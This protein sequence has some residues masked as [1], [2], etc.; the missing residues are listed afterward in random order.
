MNF[1]EW[2]LL[3]EAKK[4]SD[5]ARE[6]LGNNEN[7]FNQIKSIIPTDIKQDLQSKLV[8]VA[9]YYHKQQP[10]LNTLKQDINDYANLVKLNKMPII[11]IKD[12]HTIDNKHFQNYIGWTQ[13]IHGKQAEDKV[14]NAPIP[15]GNLEDQELIAKSTDGKIKVY[16]AN[17]VNQCIILGKGESFCISQPANTMFQSYRDTKVSTFYFVYDNTRSDDL[18]IV[19]VDATKQRIELTDRKNQ[20]AKTMQDPYSNIP[21]RIQSNPQLYFKYLKEH[22]IDTDIFENIPKNEEEEAEQQKLGEEKHDLQWFKSLTL[23]E[24]SKYIGR[25][26]LLS[27]EQF[28][29]LYDNKFM[30]LLTQ[31][32]R[33]GRKLDDYQLEK[34]AKVRDL[35]DKYLHNR[36]IANQ[37][38]ENLSKQEYELLSPKQKEEYIDVDADKKFKRAIRIGDLEKL[39]DAIKDG[40]YIYDDAVEDAVYYGHLDVTEYLVEKGANI[41]DSAVHY[42][43][44]KGHYDILKYLVEKGAKISDKAVSHAAYKRHFDIVKYLLGDETKD[45]KGNTIKLPDKIKPAKISYD[46][47]SSA[48]ENGYLDIVKYLVEKGAKISD[49]AV[50]YAAEHGHLDIIKYLLG[51]ET[52]DEKGN[53]IKLPNEIKPA[54]I[55]DNAIIYAAENGHLDVVKYL[56]EKGAEATIVK[57]AKTQEIKDY[58]IQKQKEQQAKNT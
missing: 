58:L 10:D 2:L 40:A 36:L 57:Y 42:A 53:I 54:K 49:Y 9:A 52:K 21:K 17:S 8:P 12:D 33:T 13:I 47:V 26:H 50:R 28:D 24:K 44:L 45:E 48:A 11:T 56:V 20:T 29:Y 6:L 38:D 25:G 19:V 37:N 1:K 14:S 43:A 34:V 5:I 31:Y 7:L 51:D 4:S 16:K 35:R 22:G 41:G 15:Q 55:S 27:N 3:T 39:K 30:L 18:A 23:D 46:A 32:V